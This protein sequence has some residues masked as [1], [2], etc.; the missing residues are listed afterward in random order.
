[1]KTKSGRHTIF[2]IN[3]PSLGSISDVFGVE[4]AKGGDWFFQPSHWFPNGN[5]YGSIVHTRNKTLMLYSPGFPSAEEAL[6]AAE[7]W[8]IEEESLTEFSQIEWATF[9]LK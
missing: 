8:E 7:Q 4:A 2:N 9:T 3:N 5:F 6:K 1:M